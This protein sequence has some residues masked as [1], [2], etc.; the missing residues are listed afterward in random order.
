MELRA[1]VMFYSAL[2]GATL[3]VR[4]LKQGLICFNLRRAEQ[5]LV[6]DRLNTV[7]NKL[8][9][10]SMH[11]PVVMRSDKRLCLQLYYTTTCIYILLPSFSRMIIIFCKFFC[12]KLVSWHVL[13]AVDICIF[14][15]TNPCY[16][17]A[18]NASFEYEEEG[19][20][21]KRSKLPEKCRFW[22]GCMNGD[23]C[24][25]HHPSTNCT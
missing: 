8:N 17:L 12:L 11:V 7:W 5:T 22:P 23:E 24:P 1:V 16:L 25:Y 6:F 3:P 4:A 2:L 15:F 10:V 14:G 21:G 19:E 13:N 9:F 18:E 20:G